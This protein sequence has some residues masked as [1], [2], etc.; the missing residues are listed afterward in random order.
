M[1]GFVDNGQGDRAI[2][3]F[4]EMIQQQCRPDAQAFVAA[5]KACS[6]IAEKGNS[7]RNTD[8]GKLPDPLEVGMAL[9]SHA[10]K[11]GLVKNNVF[12]A[13]ALVDMYARCGSVAD[14]SRTFHGIARRDVVAWT[15]LVL[16]V[17]ERKDGGQEALQIFSRMIESGECEPDARSFVAALKAVANLAALEENKGGG[18][19]RSEV[20]FRC[21]EKAMALHSEAARRRCLDTFVAN[22]LIDVYAKCGSLGL[23]RS[24]FESLSR[25]SSQKRWEAGSSSRSLVSWNAMIL[26]YAEN[27]EPEMALLLFTH[28]DHPPDAPTFTAA[29]KACGG[30]AR[31]EAPKSLSDGGAVKVAALEKTM[32]VH[33]RA[34]KERWDSHAFIA[35]S[36]IAVYAECGDMVDARWSFKKMAVKTLA[37]KTALLQGYADNGQGEAALELLSREFK[38]DDDSCSCVAALKACSSLGALEAGKAIHGDISRRGFDSN[39]VVA[40]SLVDFYG[41]CGSMVDAQLVFDSTSSENKDFAT[42]S[43]LV[44]GYGR[45][46]ASE[47]VYSLVDRIQEEQGQHPCEVTFLCVLNACSHAGHVDKGKSYFA[48]MSS[49]YGI[50]PGIEHY[51]CMVDLLGRANRLDEA[52]ETITAMP[53]RADVVTWTT[54]LGACRK[55]KNSRVGKIAFEELV[56]LDEKK[57]AAYLLMAGIAGEEMELSRGSSSRAQSWWTDEEGVV[58]RFVAGDFHSPGNSSFVKKLKEIPG[59]PPLSDELCGH[60]ERLAAAC[61]VVRSNAHPGSVIRIVKTHENVCRECHRIIAALSLLE[62]RVIECV[63]PAGFHTFDNG[64]STFHRQTR[65]SPRALAYSDLKAVRFSRVRGI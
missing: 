24:V 58:H 47:R 60:S 50:P 53:W 18:Q 15:S 13:N 55:W 16:G 3:L 48:A 11:N 65:R 49:K 59:A 7:G 5:I 17:A 44:A 20:N 26:A 56:R 27:N 25:T 12:V 33:A 10:A 21:L 63:D 22:T 30:L 52:L 45:Q 46:G 64:R 9:H 31:R 41:K 4:G 6:S 54:L 51:H 35:S 38:P 34:V 40:T 1:L 57:A 37:A 32:A 36:A 29:F 43:S 14:A 61:G 62:A 28:L 23:A 42:W 39:A 2:E 8:R 19:A